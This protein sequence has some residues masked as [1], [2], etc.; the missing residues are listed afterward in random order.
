MTT[1]ALKNRFALRHT[2]VSGTFAQT[3]AIVRLWRERARQRRDLAE[4]S[5]DILRDIGVSPKAARAEA[6]RPFWLG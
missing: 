4:M 6:A 1:S 2:T 3:W 5:P